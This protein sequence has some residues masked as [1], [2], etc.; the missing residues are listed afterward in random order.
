MCQ[1]KHKYLNI[2][3]LIPVVINMSTSKLLQVSWLALAFLCVASDKKH[4]PWLVQRDGRLESI[5]GQV[6]ERNKEHVTNWT[7]QS[8]HQIMSSSHPPRSTQL[9]PLRFQAPQGS[10]GLT[11]KCGETKVQ[12]VVNKESFGRGLDFPPSSL[13]LGDNPKS[14]GTCAPVPEDSTSS[15]I[16][17][18]AGLHDCDSEYKVSGD[19]LIYSNKLVFAPPP[20]VISTGNLIIRGARILLPIEC[21]RRR[22]Q[23]GRGETVRP[24]WK[25]FTST[26]RGAG[27]LRFSLRVMT[28]D[29]SGPRNSTVF[30]QGEPVNLEAAVDGQWH[31][32]LRIYVDRCVATLSS[33]PLSEPSYDIISNHGCL[34]DSRFSGS[35]S[36]FFPRGRRNA[37]RFR[38]RG[39]LSL[40]NSPGQIFVNCHLRAA[41][42]ESPSD[43]LNKACFFHPDSDRSGPCFGERRTGMEPCAA[44]AKRATAPAG[45]QSRRTACQRRPWHQRGWWTL[46]WVHSTRSCDLIGGASCQSVMS[47]APISPSCLFQTSPVGAVVGPEWAGTRPAAL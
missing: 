39:P 19:W 28:E 29:W 1:A 5:E 16:V 13:R 32:P 41:L 14:A 17:I 9:A 37:L 35:S 31:P 20:T 11:V 46:L 25:S 7:L 6:H 40:G 34:T 21:H 2:G 15:E 47:S 38:V 42:A 18:T 24:T 10:A 23:R 3:P 26:V 44:A 43:P 30:Q 4:S 45:C 22:R 8:Y 12:I 36:R 27:L 33:D